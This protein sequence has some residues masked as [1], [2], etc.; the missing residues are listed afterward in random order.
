MEEHIYITIQGDTWDNIA[1]TVYGNEKYADFLMQSN[2]PFL[3]TLVF[4]SGTVLNVPELPES[5]SKLLPIWRTSK[6]IFLRDPYD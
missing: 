4:S 2:Y 6:D 1:L 5:R 3:D